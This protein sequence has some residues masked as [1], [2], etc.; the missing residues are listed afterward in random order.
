MT[1]EDLEV[2]EPTS[3]D[4]ELE[5]NRIAVWQF[6]SQY[7]PEIKPEEPAV[8]FPGSD[9]RQPR[10]K[11]AKDLDAASNSDQ[12]SS[13]TPPSSSHSSSSSS[14]RP[15]A[16]VKIPATD[17]YQDVKKP[18]T[19]SFLLV[20]QGSE[21]P[22]NESFQAAKLRFQQEKLAGQQAPQRNKEEAESEQKPGN[23][24][25]TFSK[26]TLFTSK[27]NESVD[28]MCS[29]SGTSEARRTGPQPTVR[30]SQQSATNSIV[31]EDG[32]GKSASSFAS[33]PGNRRE[34]AISRNASTPHNSPMNGID[35]PF[36]PSSTGQF[37][38]SKGSNGPTRNGHEDWR[39]W[40]ELGIRIFDLPAST[41]TRDLYKRFSQEGTVVYIE[42]YENTKGQPDGKACVRFRYD[43]TPIT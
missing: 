8:L 35:R 22:H 16:K 2:L 21:N 38:Y 28:T 33:R 6:Q 43:H 9:N 23:I 5:Q 15:R 25:S 3:A 17:L 1:F 20:T 26:P 32:R 27:A 11:R 14:S 40:V 4:M 34:R 37:T 29:N 30:L 18:S 13:F 42:L 31:M 19:N 10:E 36:Y 12:N 24:A 39:S 7:H 41:T